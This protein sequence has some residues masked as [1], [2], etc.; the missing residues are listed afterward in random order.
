MSL[1][2]ITSSPD[3]S[4][5]SAATELVSGKMSG[6]G[7]EVC[8]KWMPRKQ[9]SCARILGHKGDCRTAEAPGV[10]GRPVRQAPLRRLA[11]P[12][13]P[14]RS[15]RKGPRRFWWTVEDLNL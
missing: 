13:S 4:I 6:T 10:S 1:D 15:N 14:L 8:G 3:W 11:R 2:S 12:K 7:R 5:E 9:A